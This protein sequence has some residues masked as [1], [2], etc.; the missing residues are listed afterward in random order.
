[1]SLV[2]VFRFPLGS[3]AVRLLIHLPE[4]GNDSCEIEC[5]AIGTK[6][7]LE[8]ELDAVLGS[9]FVGVG[10]AGIESGLAIPTFAEASGDPFQITVARIQHIR[11][12]SRQIGEVN[13][14]LRQLVREI[15]FVSD[16]CISVLVQNGSAVLV[17]LC[18]L[19][20]SLSGFAESLLCLFDC[21]WV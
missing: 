9:L 5:L 15:L 18:S 6:S 19:C 21:H 10:L 2:G 4:L 12:K 17:Q 1:M 16:Y 20:D 11:F 7:H 8:L 13:R 3:L 14:I